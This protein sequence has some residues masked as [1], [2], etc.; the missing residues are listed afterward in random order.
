M[1]R[2]AHRRE[3]YRRLDMQT[4]AALAGVHKYSRALFVVADEDVAE[5]DPQN[6]AAKGYTWLPTPTLLL[7]LPPANVSVIGKSS[8]SM[9]VA[10]R[11]VAGA[12]KLTRFPSPRSKINRALVVAVHRYQSPKVAYAHRVFQTGGH[13]DERTAREVAEQA[14]INIV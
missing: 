3:K 10:P 5:T 12:G 2:P 4:P 1:A 8:Q 13:S 7:P 11:S 9:A 6:Q 14:S